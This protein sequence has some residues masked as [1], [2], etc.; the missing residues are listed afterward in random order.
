MTTGKIT[1]DY[2]SYRKLIADCFSLAIFLILILIPNETMY[3]CVVHREVPITVLVYRGRLDQYLVSYPKNPLA[4]HLA[5]IIVV[6]ADYFPSKRA[7][8]P[9]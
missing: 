5:F 3:I 6:P 8:R 9:E 4:S 1:R 2:E 7:P